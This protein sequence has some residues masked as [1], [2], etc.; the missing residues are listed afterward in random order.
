MWWKHVTRDKE[1]VSKKRVA[2]TFEFYPDIK[3]D[4]L[5]S[6][7]LKALKHLIVLYGGDDLTE[8]F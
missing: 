8:P 5:P 1:R 3:N 2:T 6:R 7:M 4:D